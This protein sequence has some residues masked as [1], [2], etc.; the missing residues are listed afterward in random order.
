M[1]LYFILRILEFTLAIKP[2]TSTDMLNVSVDALLLSSN[3]GNSEL[4]EIC[5]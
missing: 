4:P 5:Q 2:V 1:Y 3:P